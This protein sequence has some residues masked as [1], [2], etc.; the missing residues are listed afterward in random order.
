V[1]DGS[2]LD[3]LV[4]AA[5]RGD[6]GAWEALYRRAHPRLLAYARRRLPSD[7][8]ARDAVSETMARAVRSIGRYRGEGGGFDAWLSGIVRHVVL[9]AQRSARRRGGSATVSVSLSAVVP[10]V[11]SLDPGPEDVL[12]GSFEA[13][14]VRSAFA[15]LSAADQELLELRVVLGLSSDEVAAVLGKRAGAV[16]MAQARAL[17][18]LRSLLSPVVEVRE[19]VGPRG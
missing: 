5:R 15:R 7:D 10:E 6:A 14:A 9:D 16:R 11:A 1:E 8:A 2:G 19:E 17:E 12:V 13:S 3:A 4:D 18:R